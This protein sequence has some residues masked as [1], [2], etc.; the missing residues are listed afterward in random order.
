M[1]ICILYFLMVILYA[2]MSMFY[3]LIF[4]LTPITHFKVFY[5]FISRAKTSCISVSARDTR[6]ISGNLTINP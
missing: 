3:G 2:L 4:F 5:D 6:L 1:L